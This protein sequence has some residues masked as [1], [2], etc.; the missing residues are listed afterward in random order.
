[1]I[2]SCEYCKHSELDDSGSIFAPRIYICEILGMELDEDYADDCK[3]FEPITLAGEDDYDEE[4][5]Y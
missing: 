5:D 1:M 4:E 2:R 3:D